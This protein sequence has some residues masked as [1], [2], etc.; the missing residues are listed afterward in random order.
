MSPLSDILRQRIQADGPL[1]LADFMAQALGHPQHGYYLTRDPLGQAGD[2]ITAPEISQMFG[3][4]IGLWCAIVWQ[5]MGQPSPVILAELGPGRGTLMADLLRAAAM[6]PDFRAAI[7]VHLVETSPVLRQRQAQTL[8]A[9][10]VAPQWHDDID[11]LPAG[12]MILVANEFF[13]ALPIRQYIRREDGWHERLVGLDGDAFVFVDGPVAEIDAPEAE[14]GQHFEINPSAAAIA[15][16]L[17]A[18]LADQGG[19]ALIIDYG[20]DRSAVGDTL[21]A[22]R[23]HTFAPPLDKPG[24]ADLTAHV[25]FQALSLA[26]QPARTSA[27]IP[28]GVFLRAL[29]IELRAV[30][31]MKSALDKSEEIAKACRRLIDP[32]EMGNL[33]KV[34]AV[35]DPKLP[36]PPGLPQ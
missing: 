30:R 5:S 11:A 33:F 12:P 36:P 24:E 20:H 23:H 14:I 8:A 26:F 13:D 1:S 29:G 2:F 31:L 19:A 6:V 7:R 22:V 21:Q 27:V 9:A 4:I 17:G 32:S 25:D 16:R 10:G 35:T 34:L 3:E 15:A 28:Q 18:R